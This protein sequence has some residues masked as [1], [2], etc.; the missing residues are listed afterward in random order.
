MKVILLEEV[1]NVGKAG[2]VVEVAG[3]FGRNFLIPRRLALSATRGNMKNL[4][5]T[6]A[7]IA[8]KQSRLQKQAQAL[9]KHLESSPLV[10][11]AHAGEEGR[12]HGSVT[13]HDISQALAAKGIEIDRRKIHLEEPI[14]VLGSHTV[15]IRLSAEVEAAL[16]VEVVPEEAPAEE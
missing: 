12:L 15:K 11:S 2:A 3:G 1:A 7:E 16:T 9:V 5:Q 6:R 13:T 8:K 4:E 10:V 14:R